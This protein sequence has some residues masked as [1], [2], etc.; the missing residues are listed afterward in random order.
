MTHV[1]QPGASPEQNAEPVEPERAGS[2][3]PDIS[4]PPRPVIERIGMAAIA[5]V[6]GTLFAG[7]AAVSFSSG[8]PFLGIMATI[9]T[10]M[11][12]WVGLRTLVRG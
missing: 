11:T 7:A 2:A 3:G 10:L 4:A 5:L 6:L 12:A 1:P 8:D 9:G